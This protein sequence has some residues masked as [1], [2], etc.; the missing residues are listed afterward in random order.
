MN[1]NARHFRWTHLFCSL[2]AF[3]LWGVQPSLA[4][5]SHC[6]TLRYLQHLQESRN[7]SGKAITKASDATSCGVD[8]YYNQ[9]L[10]K[11][12]K[13][14]QIFYTLEGPHRTTKAF[15]DTLAAQAERAWSLFTEK[16]G[17]H[18]PVGMKST[19]YFQQD[20]EAGYYPIE[21]MDL[22]LAYQSNPTYGVACHGCYGTTLFSF[23]EPSKSQ[24]LIDNDFKFTPQF[25]GISASYSKDGKSCSYTVANQE[26]KNKLHGY[27][28]AEKWGKAIQITII[29]E[30]YHAVQI[31]YASPFNL[32]N[33]WFEASATGMEEIGAPDVDDY[34]AYLETFF[35]FMGTS[36]DRTKEDYGAGLFFIYLYNHVDPQMDRYMWEGFSKSQSTSFIEQF[37]KVSSSKGL[38]ADSLFHDFSTRLS[39]AGSR[40]ALID[41]TFWIDDDE[42]FWPDFSFA[43]TRM[44]ST[45]PIQLN[46]LS[47]GFYSGG[48]PTVDN[49]EGSSSAILYRGNQA[50]V[51]KISS[52]T[53]IDFLQRE[54]STNVDS[55][56]WIFSRFSEKKALPQ[57]TV[58]S[59]LRAY[60]V[61]WRQGSLCFTALPTKE[62][63]IEI[64]T[65]R[66][67]LISREKYDNQTYCM[68][69]NRV[70][71]LMAPGVYR[72]RAGSHG[73]TK[74]FI[75][76]Y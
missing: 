55:V 1:R 22:D 26:L 62:N 65:R 31:Q 24:L 43:P 25:S 71:K 64:R 58:D 70:R 49:F 76:I 7:I 2:L 10:E 29:H 11:K 37:T 59:T 41:S 5:N 18:T 53:S 36:L 66:G 16:M 74:D 32:S 27:S 21:V 4:E 48:T 67:D 44:S 72:Y 6:G 50:V 45:F 39:F 54:I 63:F 30:L 38:S 51:K 8:A 69:E 34:Y 19:S 40:S 52:T 57:G 15:V 68:D 42:A 35:G 23:M 3:V 17:M 13:H 61:P 56:A 46:E 28:Y 47:Y 20:V 60:P 75:V 9:V 73:K 33:F 12:S 14:F